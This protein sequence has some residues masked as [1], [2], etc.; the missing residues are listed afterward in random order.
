[1]SHEPI[2]I[3]GCVVRPGARER[4]EIPVGRRITGAEV[5]LPVEVVHGRQPGPR[6][7]VCAAVHGDEINGVEIIRRVLRRRL[8]RRLRG[9]LIAVPVV[10]LYG[11]I[12]LSRY[13]PDRRDLNRLFPGQ[14]LNTLEPP[15][16]TYNTWQRSI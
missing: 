4:L 8:T 5:S 12:G 3:G 10:N 6:L 1:M 16:G 9:T 7:F 15:P 11:F 2:E 14:A 13:L